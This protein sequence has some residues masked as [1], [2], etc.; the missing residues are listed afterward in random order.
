[1]PFWKKREP[2][3]IPQQ[4]ESQT[5]S[6]VELRDA[7]AIN[8]IAQAGLNGH[9]VA[10]PSLLA[11]SCPVSSVPSIDAATVETTATALPA[12]QVD[13]MLTAIHE[14]VRPIEDGAL[15][16]YIPELA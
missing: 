10:A 6:A 1:M 15:A 12:S 13:Q 7:A 5:E 14:Q 11:M 4:M 3:G 8:G 2:G 16:D 9:P